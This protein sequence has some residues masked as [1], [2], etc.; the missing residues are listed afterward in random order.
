MHSGL[1]VP[2]GVLFER[3]ISHGRPAWRKFHEDS[4]DDGDD[5]DDYDD[6]NLTG[7]S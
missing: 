3:R 4:G 1:V 6:D 5:D 2:K 7:Q